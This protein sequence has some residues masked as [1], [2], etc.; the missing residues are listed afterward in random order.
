MTVAGYGTRTKHK[1]DNGYCVE[2]AVRLR[3]KGVRT[4]YVSEHCFSYSCVARAKGAKVTSG[5]ISSFSSTGSLIS[6]ALTD[7]ILGHGARWRR[8]AR[9]GPWGRGVW[10]STDTVEDHHQV[11]H[12]QYAQNERGDR[13]ARERP[14]HRAAWFAITA[15]DRDAR[16]TLRLVLQQGDTVLV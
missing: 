5:L 12:I 10:G 11:P 6:S 2:Y 1:R 8:G 4:V 7:A 13:V 16:L 14:G 9:S 3:H 15:M